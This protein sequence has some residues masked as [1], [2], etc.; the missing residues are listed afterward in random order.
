MISCT[1]FRL[2]LLIRPSIALV[3]GIRRQDKPNPQD[4]S[5]PQEADLCPDLPTEVCACHPG[6]AAMDD[7]EADAERV[8][9]GAIPHRSSAAHHLSS[10]T[11]LALLANEIC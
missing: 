4:L 8:L 6:S 1:L 3:S 5:V 9:Q 10:G 7:D 11:G 2:A